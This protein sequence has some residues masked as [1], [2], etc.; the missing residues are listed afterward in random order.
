MPEV[1][2]LTVAHLNFARDTD[3]NFDRRCD[4][5]EPPGIRWHRTQLDVTHVAGHRI[6]V[7]ERF[8]LELQH[9]QKLFAFQPVD[10]PLI[11]M[12]GV[13]P[14]C[15]AFTDGV[16]EEETKAARSTFPVS[17]TAFS[18]SLKTQ[19]PVRAKGIPAASTRL[20]TNPDDRTQ[21]ISLEEC[22]GDCWLSSAFF[23]TT[24]TSS[25]RLETNGLSIWRQTKCSQSK[26][27]VLQ[28]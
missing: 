4:A 28:S 24:W 7:G 17:A 8:R 11:N 15:A 27:R 14:E 12:D 3:Q 25:R 2:K 9:L 23:I 10:R 20:Q 5:P 18:R 21:P 1:R 16:C 19:G 6:K 13:R 22:A 26:K